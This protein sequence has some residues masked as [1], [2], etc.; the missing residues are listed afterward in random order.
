MERDFLPHSD[1][2]S[3]P[4]WRCLVL[5]HSVLGSSWTGD[6]TLAL[7]APGCLCTA[8][9]EPRLPSSPS[10]HRGPA[11]CPGGWP[12]QWSFPGEVKKNSLY[13]VMWEIFL[14]E[15]HELILYVGEKQIPVEPVSKMLQKH[16]LLFCWFHQGTLAPSEL[17]FAE[18]QGNSVLGLHCPKAASFQLNG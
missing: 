7:G 6:R 17:L 2:N 9:G 16:S 15:K 10:T 5:L 11:G 4:I 18:H 8:Q 1:L 12:S 13:S 3:G 14:K